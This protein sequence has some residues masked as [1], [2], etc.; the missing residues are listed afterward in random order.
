MSNNGTP[1]VSHQGRV[2]GHVG[3][4]DGA[5]TAVEHDA[6]LVGQAGSPEAVQIALACG[7]VRDRDGPCQ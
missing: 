3:G 6:V 1:I 4:D 2:A 5:E 7:R